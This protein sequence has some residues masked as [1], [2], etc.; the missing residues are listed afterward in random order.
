MFEMPTAAQL[1]RK[2]AEFALE[3][4]QRRNIEVVQSEVG[5]TRGRKLIFNTDEGTA[6]L[7]LI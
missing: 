5:G 3:F 7:T 6:C 4:L 1:G 2:N